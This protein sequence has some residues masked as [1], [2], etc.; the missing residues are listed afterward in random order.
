MT[1]PRL[2]H[3]FAHDLPELVI[4]WQAEESPDPALLIL[5]EPLAREL[6]L[7]VDW[8]R[9]DEGVDF[10]L[11]HGGD[12]HAMAYSGHQF[13]QFSPQLGDGRALLLGELP[14]G[15]GLV[16]LHIKGSGPTPFSRG[17]D[18]RGAL[19]PMLREYLVSEAMHALGVPTTR[20]LAVITTGRKIQRGRVVPAAIL[21][22]VAASHLRVGTMQYARLR[23]EGLG[24][25]AR[26]TDHVRARHY[27][28]LTD[29]LEVFTAVMD[30]QVATVA[31]W[32][33][34]GFIHGVM[35]TDNT[36][37]SG[38]TIDYGPCAFMDSFDPTTVYSSIDT[39][40]RY[41]YR[42]QPAVL[43]WNL[44]RLAEAMLPLFN[45]DEDRAVDDARQA[46]G[47]FQDRWEKATTTELARA[48]DVPDTATDV[49]AGYEQLLL[50]HSPDLTRFHRGL[51]SA[52][53]GDDTT[54]REMIP[55]DD[56]DPWLTRWLGH[57]P[58]AGR[59]GRIHPVYIPRNH[60]V[61]EALSAAVD[62]DLAPFDK[63]LDAV[64]HPFDEK[65]DLVRY[66]H[67]APEDFGPYRTFCGT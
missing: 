19:G 56:L 33:R 15:A 65:L 62:G 39:Q 26:L 47:T 5:N 61:E 43:G 32:M 35:N 28:Q 7:D 16:D 55:A 1:T 31:Q 40:G 6:G 67:P 13:G 63:L 38:E 34:L 36:T 29:P 66:A 3:T 21:V 27:P 41:A 14:T 51:V 10:L 42:N 48:L 20:S 57:S 2:D 37:L 64:T 30:R 18:G 60:L 52:A 25:A 58:D 53:G 46:M 45:E 59:L 4:S 12:T 17:G 9:S 49:I 50:D 54:L 11:G 24:L 22:R 8:L 44:A 23:D